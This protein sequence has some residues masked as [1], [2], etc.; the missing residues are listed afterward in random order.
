M[1]KITIILSSITLFGAISTILSPVY[2]DIPIGSVFGQGTLQG[3]IGRYTQIT[4]LFNPLLA[5]VYIVAG[6]IVF[7]VLLGGGIL[8]ILGAGESDSKKINQGKQTIAVGLGGLTLVFVSY[9]L[10]KIIEMVTGLNILGA[11]G[12]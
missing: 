10:I 11:E 7:F 3:A 2:A 8:V 5:T 4:Q 1:K 12:L 9:W 6:L